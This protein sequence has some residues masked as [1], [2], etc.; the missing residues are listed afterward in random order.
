MN[1]A[2]FLTGRNDYR[3]RILKEKEKI[4]TSIKREDAA[5]R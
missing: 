5:S 1:S 2:L 3:M 4:L